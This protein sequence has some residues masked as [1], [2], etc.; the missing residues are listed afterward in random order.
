VI[1]AVDPDSVAPVGDATMVLTS[2]NALLMDGGPI[3]V[4]DA[5]PVLPVPP[6]VEVTAL[7]ESL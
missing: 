5:V 7:V 4:S 1:V 6:L 2:S 3:T